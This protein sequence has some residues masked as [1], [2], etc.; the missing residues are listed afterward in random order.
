MSLRKIPSNDYPDI[1]INELLPI[2]KSQL[3]RCGPRSKKDEPT[4]RW[5]DSGVLSVATCTCFGSGLLSLRKYF[6]E[7]ESAYACRCDKAILNCISHIGKGILRLGGTWDSLSLQERTREIDS[8]VVQYENAYA[9]YQ[10]KGIRSVMTVHQSKGREFDAVIVP[11]FSTMKWDERDS[12]SWD[13]SQKEITNFFH[14]ACTRAKEEVIVIVPRDSE[15]S[16]PLE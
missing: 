12:F 2:S 11:W 16:W 14:T 7:A 10:K 13:T 5:R 1:K 8:L 4:K 9:S 6:L 3:P 15:A